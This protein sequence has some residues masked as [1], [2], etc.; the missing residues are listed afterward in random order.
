M[1]AVGSSLQAGK[2]VTTEV[3]T[4]ITALG[5]LNL[6]TNTFITPNTLVTGTH[7]KFRLAATNK[8][9]TGGTSPSS[10]RM[11][12]ALVPDSPTS[13]AK[14]NS[15]TT[16]IGVQWVAPL[17]NG[18]A[19]VWN[20]NIYSNMGSGTVFSLAGTTAALSFVH[21]NLSPSGATFLYKVSAINDIGESLL[22]TQASI[23]LGTV[24]AQPS[25]P[26]YS[27]S[28]LTS[29]TVSYVAPDNGGTSITYYLVSINSGTAGAY[30]QVGNTTA[31]QYTATGLTTGQSYQFR[32]QA[33]NAIGASLVSLASQGILS[34]V[35]PNA[36][37]T[38][39]YL[40]STKT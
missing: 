11:I 5:V 20:Y 10:A 33:F 29:I 15:T 12:A 22:S 30:V 37:G 21:I 23:I 25:A 24:P 13:P 38:P 34:A 39:T 7:Y 40:T 9:G 19:T 6:A 4:D 31:L 36:P 2:N 27:S 35:V 28:T 26:V 1:A 14:L 8:V 16:S 3:Y 32:V 17:N 18:G